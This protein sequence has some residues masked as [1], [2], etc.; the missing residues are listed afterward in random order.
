MRMKSLTEN[1]SSPSVTI[2]SVS[3][4]IQPAANTSSTRMSMAR[5][6]PR[7]RARACWATGSREERIEMKITL[8]TPST[9]SSTK[10]VRK[11]AI[12]SGESSSE[13]SIVPA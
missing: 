2:G 10:S 7:F 4:M 9:S 5:V 3:V 13:K 6:R 8:S 1:S 11:T 12:R